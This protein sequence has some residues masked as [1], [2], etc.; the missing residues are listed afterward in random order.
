MFCFFG[1]MVGL[2]IQYAMLIALIT[3]QIPRRQTSVANGILAFL[4]MTGSLFGFSLF[5]TYL[6]EDIGSMYGLYTCIVITMMIWTGTHAHERDAELYAERLSRRSHRQTTKVVS[7][8]GIVIASPVH[9][10]WHRKAGKVARKAAKKVVKKAH[11]LYCMRDFGDC[12]IITNFCYNFSPYGDHMYDS[13][14]CQWSIS[15]H[16]NKFGC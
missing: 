5:H 15:L 7:E 1:S 4:L 10:Q 12:N 16:G 2:N 11:N 9:K 6:A 3:D 13:G 8:S 14:G